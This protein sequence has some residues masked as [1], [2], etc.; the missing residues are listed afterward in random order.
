MRYPNRD[1]LVRMGLAVFAVYLG[2][3]YWSSISKGLMLLLAALVPVLVGGAIAYIA[4]IPMRFFE[5]KLSWMADKPHL[6]KLRRPVSLLAA[7]GIVV[8]L[9][10]V[11]LRFIVPELMQSMRTYDVGLIYEWSGITDIAAN[12]VIKNSTDIMSLYTKVSEKIEKSMNDAYDAISAIE[13]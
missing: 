12:C 2:I 4:N 10:G 13:G 6:A 1:E 3:Y 11:L 9:S 7:I 8:V 5:E